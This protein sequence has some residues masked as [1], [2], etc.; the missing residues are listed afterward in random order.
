M[1]S[2]YLNAAVTT[3]ALLLAG[4]LWV[5]LS[6]NEAS[7]ATPASAQNG[8]RGIPNAGAQRAEIVNKLDRLADAVDGLSNQLDGGLD[9]NVQ[10][11]PASD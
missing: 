1:S 10:N 3:V 9:V 6:A 11:F 5:S 2:R 8:N 7:T 4:N